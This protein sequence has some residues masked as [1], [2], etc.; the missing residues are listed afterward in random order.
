[1]K[2]SICSIKKVILKALMFSVLFLFPLNGSFCYAMVNGAGR[3]EFVQP[4][5][6]VN[7]GDVLRH[8]NLVNMFSVSSKQTS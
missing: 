3:A 5:S 4:K 6:D 1:M 8:F 7:N 2:K